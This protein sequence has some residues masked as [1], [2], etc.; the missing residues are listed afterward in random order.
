MSESTTITG[1]EPELSGAQTAE[2]KYYI[3]VMSRPEN[4]PYPLELYALA[5]SREQADQRAQEW[6]NEHYAGLWEMTP[7]GQYSKIDRHT[8]NNHVLAYVADHDYY[9]MVADEEAQQRARRQRQENQRS[10][11]FQNLHNVLAAIMVAQN[12]NRLT[13][14][15]LLLCRIRSDARVSIRRDFE[16]DV[17]EILLTD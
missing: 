1:E 13:V 4:P 12:T 5:T 2:Q 7:E 3:Y 6:L 15:S 16:R 11:E 10:E 14:S 8:P 9:Q 17:Y